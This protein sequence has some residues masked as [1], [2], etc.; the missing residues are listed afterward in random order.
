[1][2]ISFS[3]C[4]A[5]K[6]KPATISI[7][8]Q[9][10]S[11]YLANVITEL[12]KKWPNNRT[13]NLVFHGHSVPSGYQHT[14]LITTFDSYPLLSLNLITEKYPFAVVNVIKTCIGG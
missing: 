1:M 3:S 7:S 13:I 6:I 2:L 9:V 10:D 14:P 5:E 8:Q 12:Q 4:A 11:S